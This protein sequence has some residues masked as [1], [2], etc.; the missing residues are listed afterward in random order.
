MAFHLAIDLNQALE[1]SQNVCAIT[2][3]PGVSAN[4]STNAS[5]WEPGEFSNGVNSWGP[6]NNVFIVHSAGSAAGINQRFA[7]IGVATRK[8]FTLTRLQA[9]VFSNAAGHSPTNPVNIAVEISSEDDF[10]T[11]ETAGTITTHNESPQILSVNIYIPSGNTYIRLRSTSPIPDG[12]NFIAYSNITLDGTVIS[13]AVVNSLKPI[14]PESG[15]QMASTDTF[16][17]TYDFN[18]A[19][20]N[21]QIIASARPARKRMV[22]FLSTNAS[23]H[24]PGEFG[25]GIESW[26]PNNNVF[27]LHNSGAAQGD[28]QRYAYVMI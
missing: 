2:N 25:N 18:K 13:D 10:L 24:E 22:C 8:P 27:I 7:Y 26:G 6:G 3:V 21:V 17:I 14:D 5:Q 4:I 9:L 12:S 19:A 28:N 16:A 23:P 20:P 11:F 1:I 15:S